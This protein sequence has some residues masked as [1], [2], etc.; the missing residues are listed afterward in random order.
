MTNWVRTPEALARLAES[1]SGSAALALDTESDSL[2][3]H[4]EKVCLVQLAT[5]RGDACLVDPLALRDLSPLAPVM[6][7][8]RVVKV[9][10]GADYDVTTL[11]RDF[12]FRFAALFDTMIAA[13]FLGRP[14]IGLQ[15]L[16][17]A[18]LGVALSKESQRDDWSR[19]PLTATQERYALADVSHLLVLQA[20]LAGELSQLGRLA[21]VEEESRAVAAL[22]PARRGRDPE[23]YQRVKGMRRLSR[24][25]QAVLREAHGWRETLAEATDVPAFKLLSSEALLE[26]AERAPRTAAEL[27]KVRG[28]SPRVKSRGDELLAA[29]GR[30]LDLPEADLPRLSPPAPRPVVS[31]AVRQ[32]IDSLR[33]WRAKAAAGLAVDVSVVLPQRL[34]E[35]L[36]HAAPRDVEALREIDGLRRWRVEAFGPELVAVL[37]T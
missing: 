23:A 11:K 2:H 9:L 12:G 21:W 24:R 16:A 7:D 10:H 5:D 20:R 14:Q 28:L 4:V 36:A 31:E 15:A 22:E 18:E 29:I 1:L 8:P 19:R 33:A 37:G 32:R 30:A 27:G 3:H 17:Q 35:R 34:L 25:Q 13:R 26:I 6:A